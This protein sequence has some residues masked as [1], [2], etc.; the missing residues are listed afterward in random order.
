MAARNRLDLLLVVSDALHTDKYHHCS[1]TTQGIL[2]KEATPFISELVELAASCIDEKGSRFED[3]LRAI[4]NYWALNKMINNEGCK[5]LRESAEESLTI[6]QGGVPT[7]KRNYLLPEYHGDKT[8]PWY[9]LPASYMLEQMV[10]QPNRPIDPY[11]IK[12]AR[13]DKKPVSSHVRTLLDNYFE[14]IDLK[15]TP[16]GDNPSSET[17]KHNIWLDPMGQLVKQDKE[18]GETA[19]VCNGYGWSMKFCQDM[20]KG[21]VPE[22]IQKAREDAERMEDVRGSGNTAEKQRNER[23][24]SSSPQRRRRSSSHSL[25]GRDRSRRGRSNSRGSISSYDSY[26]DRSRSHVRHHERRHRS[27]RDESRHYSDRG[28]EFDDREKESRRPPQ[29]VVKDP[30]RGGVQ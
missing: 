16:T 4:L 14:N 6:A 28:R 21:N 5:A 13:L 9:E 30:P 10:E 18:T 24:Y 19:T 17:K 11:R 15:Y 7:R 29:P 1:R 27:P 26:D 20:Q 22:S 25:H 12:V 23:N 3:K 8:A 2:G